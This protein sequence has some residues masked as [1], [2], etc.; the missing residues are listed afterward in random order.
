MI[1][2]AV[3]I[4]L[5]EAER[6]EFVVEFWMVPFGGICQSGGRAD[7]CHCPSC[8]LQVDREY[9]NSRDSLVLPE[10][11]THLELLLIRRGQMS[12]I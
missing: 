6:V 3:E 1:I 10:L 4:R 9:I 11:P 2:P 5:A 12:Q 8:V 7:N